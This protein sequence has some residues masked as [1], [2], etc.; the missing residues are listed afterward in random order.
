MSQE[1]RPWWIWPLLVVLLPLVV[2]AGV[3][4]LLAAVLLQLLVW[5]TWCPRGRYAVV[6]YSNSP[7][8]QLYFEE[9]ILPAIGARGLPRQPRDRPRIGR[10]SSNPRIWG[11]THHA[12]PPAAPRNRRTRQ[13]PNADSSQA[14]VPF[15][16]PVDV[17][18][19]SAARTGRHLR[20]G[21]VIHV[22]ANPMTLR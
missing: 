15:A 20:T 1:L 2:A 5:V 12:S 22:H 14:L 7:I 4:W 10:W 13:T 6:V 11:S 17:R 18:R 8:W 19:S 21:R 9:N 16:A 3:L